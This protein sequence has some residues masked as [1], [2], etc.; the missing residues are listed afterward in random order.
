[1][2]SSDLITVSS[3]DTVNICMELMTENRIRHLPV[4]EKDHLVGIVSIGDVVKDVIDELQFIVKQLE[5]Y[6]M[7][8]R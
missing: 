8:V 4:L 7:G 1:V 6:I 3:N 2:M 5:N